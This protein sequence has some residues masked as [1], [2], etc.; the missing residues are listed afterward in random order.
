MFG[1]SVFQDGLAVL[2]G[3]LL[4]AALFSI[5]AMMSDFVLDG[6]MRFSNKAATLGALAFFGYVGVATFI[7]VYKSPK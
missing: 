2:L 5:V 4:F 1:S 3:G 7:K 6:E